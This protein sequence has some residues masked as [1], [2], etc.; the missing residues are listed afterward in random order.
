MFIGTRKMSQIT[1]PQDVY[2]NHLKVINGIAFI[3]PVYTTAKQAG[4]ADC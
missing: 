3:S 1:L 2:E 4:C